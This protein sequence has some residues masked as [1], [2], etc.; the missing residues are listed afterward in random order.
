[1]RKPEASFEEAC[2]DVA[3]QIAETVISKQHDYGHQNILA[4]REKGLVVRLTDKLARLT[5]LIWNSESPKNESIDD[6]FVDIAGYAIIGLMLKNNTFTY[7]LKEPASRDP[8]GTDTQT[9]RHTDR[10]THRHSSPGEP[11][12]PSHPGTNIFRSAPPRSD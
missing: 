4:F 3:T 11:P 2:R 1:M 10:Q 8:P 9:D 6:T 5:N 7:D 12:S